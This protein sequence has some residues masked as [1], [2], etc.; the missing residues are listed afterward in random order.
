MKNEITAGRVINALKFHAQ[1]KLGIETVEE[2][3]KR[4]QD[5]NEAKQ[6]LIDY[7]KQCKYEEQELERRFAEIEKMDKK[8]KELIAKKEAEMAIYIEECLSSSH[9]V[10]NSIS[11]SSNQE[12]NELVAKS[13]INETITSRNQKLGDLLHGYNSKKE[14]P[15]LFSNQTNSIEELMQSL[16]TYSSA[17]C[18]NSNKKSTKIENVQLNNDPIDELMNGLSFSKSKSNSDEFKLNKNSLDDLLDSL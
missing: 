17:S 10:I 5:E 16:Q 6:A 4:I 9:Q 11:T 8:E 12:I 14:E 1:K 7:E 3:N 15:I 2:K 13:N 18:D